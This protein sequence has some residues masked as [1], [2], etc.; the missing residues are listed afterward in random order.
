MK[1]FQH[2]SLAEQKTEDTHESFL[3]AL[4]ASFSIFMSE[5]YVGFRFVPE[6]FIFYTTGSISFS[7]VVKYTKEND[8]WTQQLLSP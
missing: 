6:T 5:F 8:A 2:H 3:S 4:I 1:H 7:E